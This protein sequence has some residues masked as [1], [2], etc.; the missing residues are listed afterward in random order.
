MLTG[1]GDPASVILRGN[2]QCLKPVWIHKNLPRERFPDG[3][4]VPCGVCVNCRKQKAREWALRINHETRDSLYAVF[5]TLTYNNQC[6][7]KNYGLRKKHLQNFIKRLRKNY[8]CTK[9]KYYACG[10][11]G[12][13][14]YRPHYHIILLFLKTSK[15]FDEWINNFDERGR[16]IYTGFLEKTWA[17]GNVQASRLTYGRILYTVSYVD[18]KILNYRHID[19]GKKQPPFKLSSNGFGLSYVKDNQAEL[20]EVKAIKDRGKLIGLPRYYK[21]K[22]A[23]R[24]EELHRLARS[25]ELEIA[26]EY[27]K[28]IGVTNMKREHWE[29]MYAAM[30]RQKAINIEAKGKIQCKRRLF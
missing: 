8:P 16:K 28:N 10:E 2:M 29:S 1:R 22:L 3:L 18:K 5:A 12:D 27:M 6:V 23:I 11:Y 24:P 13:M 25:K 9:I 15:S 20:L 17:Q 4:I 19:I 30:N 21:K 26:K 14:L 7:P